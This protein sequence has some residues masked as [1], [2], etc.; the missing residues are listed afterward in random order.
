VER[1]LTKADKKCGRLKERVSARP[2]GG[3]HNVV[4]SPASGVRVISVEGRGKDAA[5]VVYRYQ[6][7]RAAGG[8][9]RPE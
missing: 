1:L 5:A 8:A 4:C 2:L 9:G 6:A 3:V 7:K